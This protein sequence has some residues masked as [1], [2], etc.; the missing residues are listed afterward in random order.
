M[1]YDIEFADKA[2]YA[3]WMLTLT[4]NLTKR[5]YNA[6]IAGTFVGE[7]THLE[8]ELFVKCGIPEYETLRSATLLPAKALGIDGESGTLEPGKRADLLVL[9]KNPLV[10]I[11]N[12]RTT[13]AVYANCMYWEKGP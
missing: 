9:D 13:F 8:M 3:S 6:G 11:R 7:A 2:N 4:M 12:I 5:L 10:D 1:Y